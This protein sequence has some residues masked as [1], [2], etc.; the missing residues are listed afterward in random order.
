MPSTLSERPEELVR[1]FFV[2]NLSS[3]G[4]QG[5]DPKQD[6]PQASDFLP[7]TTD[8]SFRGNYYPFISVR[9]TEGPTLPNSGDTNYNGL[10]GDGSGP[11]Q[12]SD[13]SI[14]VSVQATQGPDNDGAPYLN[15]T[16]A[17]NLVHDI[18]RECQDTVQANPALDLSNSGV[19]LKGMTP[20]TITRNNEETDSGST[21]TWMQAQGTVAVDFTDEP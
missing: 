3:G 16:K 9:S 11:I 1:Q 19:I 21:I 6:D 18:Y 8:W 13:R 7:I 10:A 4:M 14:T 5:Y 20:P 2:D 15:N 17:E 12:R